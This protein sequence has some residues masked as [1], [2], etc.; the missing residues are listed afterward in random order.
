MELKRSDV[1]AVHVEGLMRV[2]YGT[3]DA[4][5]RPDFKRS[6]KACLLAVDVMTREELDGTAASYGLATPG[7][8][9]G[10]RLV[11]I[12]GGDAR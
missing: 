8:D 11:P 9:H 10:L 7:A 4:I 5:T 3:L 1:A 12:G 6:V 2:Q